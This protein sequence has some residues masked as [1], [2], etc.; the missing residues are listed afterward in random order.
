MH[1]FGGCCPERTSGVASVLTS[2]ALLVGGGSF[3]GF[4]GC[5]CEVKAHCVFSL[6]QSLSPLVVLQREEV[7][8]EKVW[9]WH[10]L[11]EKSPR[12]T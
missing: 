9:L 3:F 7:I 1:Q 10:L 4:V 8:F 5:F 2:T 6:N 12:K 11:E